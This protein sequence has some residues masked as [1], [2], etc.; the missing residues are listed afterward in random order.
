MLSPLLYSLF[1]HD[2]VPVYG[3]KTIIK[4]ADDTTVVG[5]IKDD[6]ESAY[7]DEVQ[8]LAVWCATN[9]LELN[10][11]KTKEIVVDFRRTRSHA[12]TSIYI[13]GSVVER[14]SKFLSINISD[15]LTW[16]LNTSSP[17]I[18]VDFYR[19]TIEGWAA[20]QCGIAIAPHQIAKH[21]SRWWKYAQRIIGTQLT[22]IENIYHKRCLGRARNIIKNASHPNHGL[23]TILP[24]GRRY[25]SLRSCTS[26]LR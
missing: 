7:R 9:N 8:H 10:T 3:S 13:N 19:Y 17:R 16:S 22:T 11:Q 5:L 14:V 1:T 12:H 23:F 24:S 21:S 18:L 20:S 15:D 6:D 2:C 25:R 4:L 26:R